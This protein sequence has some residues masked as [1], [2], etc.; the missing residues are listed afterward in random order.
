MN[1]MVNG[2]TRSVDAETTVA[3]LLALLELPPAG[4]AVAVNEEIVAHGEH[5]TSKLGDGDRVE[6]V[7]AIGGG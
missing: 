4:L 6:I 1:I 5:A 3:D 7:K 2:N